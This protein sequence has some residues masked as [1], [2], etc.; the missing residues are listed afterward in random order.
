MPASIAEIVNHLKTHPEDAA[1]VRWVGS[2][3]KECRDRYGRLVT[4]LP[5]EPVQPR[6]IWIEGLQKWVRED[7]WS[8]SGGEYV[9]P[10]LLGRLRL[11]YAIKRWSKTPHGRV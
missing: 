6:E 1:W 10:R 7:G 11:R 9:Y 5:G 3:K 4:V 2:E 8:I